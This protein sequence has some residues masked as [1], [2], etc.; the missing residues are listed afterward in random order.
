[1]TAF[2]LIFGAEI[3]QALSEMLLG[4]VNAIPK[5]ITAIV[6]FIIG[7]IIASISKKIVIKM[8][9]KMNLDSIGNQINSIDILQKNN[10][11]IKLSQIFGKVIYFFLLLIFAM[12]AI[13]V[14]DMPV[15]AELIRD[16]IQ[17][18]PNLIAAFII[19]LAG[20]LLADFLKNIVHTTC[21]SLGMPSAS[22]I[23]TFVFYFIF[24]N[25]L[26][27]AL[28]QAKI[29][30]DFIEQNISIVIAGGVLAFSIGYGLASKEI[31]SSFLASFYTKDRFKIGDKVRIQGVEGRILDFDKTSIT[32]ETEDRNVVIPL[33]KLIKENI[34]IFH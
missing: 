32:I 27:V 16:F 24:I 3:Q 10:I 34:E 31:V 17:F 29:N 22:I 18:V 12:T 2:A 25:I 6:I 26:I 4:L 20:I 8:S 21:K 33:G 7:Y 30:T 11:E 9:N 19:L 5:F 15:L 14:L 28:S 13:G 23:S 1:M